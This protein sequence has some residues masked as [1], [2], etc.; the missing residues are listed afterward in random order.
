MASDK[1]KILLEIDHLTNNLKETNGQIDLCKRKLRKSLKIIEDEGTCMEKLGEDKT[2]F[3]SLLKDVNLY[4]KQSHQANRKNKIKGEYLCKIR[5]KL[6]RDRYAAENWFKERNSELTKKIRSAKQVLKELY[7]LV[8]EKNEL[9]VKQAEE[10]KDADDIKL[11][12]EYYEA[13]ATVI[14]NAWRCYK[15]HLYAE[16]YFSNLK[17]KKYAAKGILEQFLNIK[18]WKKNRNSLKENPN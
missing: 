17:G 11:E 6:Y 10:L 9:I 13:A 18:A 5:E 7:K 1:Y 12:L 16:G 8:K 2:R 14:Q 3:V 15:H 4:L